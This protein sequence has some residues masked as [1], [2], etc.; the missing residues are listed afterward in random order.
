MLL[1]SLYE[2]KG[3]GFD[4]LLRT[5]IRAWVANYLSEAFLKNDKQAYLKGLSDKVKSLTTI[6]ITFGYEPSYDMLDRVSSLIDNAVGKHVILR[7]FCDPTLI[8]GVEIIFEGQFRDF[9]FQRIF[10]EEFEKSR[11]VILRSLDKS[12]KEMLVISQ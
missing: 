11:E 8:G 10:E 5:R 3:L 12:D 1:T 6:E 9:S 7:T 2:E 4:R